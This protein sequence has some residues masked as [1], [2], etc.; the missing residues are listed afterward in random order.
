MLDGFFV[1]PETFEHGGGVEPS[2]H[3]AARACEILV[4]V[5]RFA[6]TNLRERQIVQNALI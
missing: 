2:G 4:S 6:E 3:F 5:V 1:A